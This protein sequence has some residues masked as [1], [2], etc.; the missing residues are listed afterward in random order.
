M[1]PSTAVPPTET[2]IGALPI[3]VGSQYTLLWEPTW[4]QLYTPHQGRPSNPPAARTNTTTFFVGI[5]EKIQIST[6]N[7][8]PW[9]WRRILFTAKGLLP[10]DGPYRDYTSRAVELSNESIVMQRS[11][12]PLPDAMASDLYRY[13]FRGLGTN[14]DGQLPRDW[15]NRITA[16]V[17]TTRVNVMYDKVVNIRSGNVHGVDFNAKRYHPIGRNVVYG[18]TEDGGELQ[19][20]PV[21]TNNKPGVGDIY[22]CDMISGSGVNDTT[23]GSLYFNPETTVYWH[24]K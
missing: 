2:A 5:K 6:T 19:S 11:N 24:E 1:L 16:P 10:I 3:D 23:T 18:D 9:Q 14:T 22:I 20:V 17:D 4:R 7:G 13:L 8:Q 21:S 12:T 15:I